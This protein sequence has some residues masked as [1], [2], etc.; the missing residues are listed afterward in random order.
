MINYEILNKL[1]DLEY[2]VEYLDNCN[3]NSLSK[4]DL[5]ELLSY[6]IEAISL[7]KE[8]LNFLIKGE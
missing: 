8:L 3:L 1:N 2:S 7:Q 4:E 6:L 5:Q